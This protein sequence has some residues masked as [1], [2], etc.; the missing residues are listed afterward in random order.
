MFVDVK[1]YGGGAAYDLQDNGSMIEAL[2]N[3]DED[4]NNDQPCWVL[5]L[6]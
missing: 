5:G 1:R 6:R 4:G 3:V 2:D